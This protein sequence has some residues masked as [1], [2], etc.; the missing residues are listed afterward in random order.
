MAQLMIVFV[1][2]LPGESL[3][4]DRDRTGPAGRGPADLV[5]EAADEE[6]VRRQRLQV[7]QLLEMAIPDVATALC[8]SQISDASRVA[9]YLFAVCTKGASQLQAS[10]P[11]SR[12]C[13]SA[14]VRLLGRLTGDIDP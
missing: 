6:A 8:P 11:V 3:V 13:R 9:S 12:R 7:V 5:R 2:G 10:V 4:E 1:M 14:D